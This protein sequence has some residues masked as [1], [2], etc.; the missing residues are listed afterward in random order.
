MNNR[1]YLLALPLVLLVHP[2]QA[3]DVRLRGSLISS[4]ILSLSTEGRL[5]IAS[6]PTVFGSEETGGTPATMTVVAVGV[7]PSVN[8]TAPSV[9]GPSGFSANAQVAIRYT[10]LGGSNQAY[11]SSASSSSAVRLLD[12]FTINGRVVSSDGFQAGNYTVRTT[13]TCQQ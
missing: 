10:S 7:A 6:D 12:T 13:A 8:F 9:D 2:A 5:S 3:A 1:I 4:C 11:T